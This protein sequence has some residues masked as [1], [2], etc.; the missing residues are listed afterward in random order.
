MG[1]RGE[2]SNDGSALSSKCGAVFLI[3]DLGLLF[4]M[5]AQILCV[6]APFGLFGRVGREHSLDGPGEGQTGVL[7]FS[8][9]RYGVALGALREA[10]QP[11]PL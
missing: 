4:S 1:S 9:G 11:V 2:P 5:T 6:G 3:A 10:A 7:C 8:R